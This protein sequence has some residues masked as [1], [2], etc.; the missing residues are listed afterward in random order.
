MQKYDLSHG[1]IKIC[2]RRQEEEDNWT[3][4][5]NILKEK[6]TIKEC[7]KR[8]RRNETKS[9]W[10]HATSRSKKTTEARI[11]KVKLKK[12]VKMVSDG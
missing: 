8:K 3:E 10:W 1:K 2:T 6:K 5:K 12:S 9:K 11:L 7:K 4:E